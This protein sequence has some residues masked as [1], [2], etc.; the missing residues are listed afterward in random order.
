MWGL[1]TNINEQVIKMGLK[2][3]FQKNIVL[4]NELL[5]AIGNQLRVVSYRKYTDKKGILPDGITFTL[6]ILHD[7]TKYE[8]DKDGNMPHDMVYET[9][10]ATVLTGS[11]S[12]DVEKGDIIALTGFREDVSFYINYSYILRFDGY[13]KLVLKQGVTGNAPTGKETTR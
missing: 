7:N 3:M 5:T 12:V 4:G 13:K 11:H 10:E 9:F 2:A 1:T 8:L 6:Q